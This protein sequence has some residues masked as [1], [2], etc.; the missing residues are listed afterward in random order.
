[1]IP[2]RG[3]GNILCYRIRKSYQLNSF[4]YSAKKILLQVDGGQ[5]QMQI[6]IHIQNH[7]VANGYVQCVGSNH[8][9]SRSDN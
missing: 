3:N 1:M 2:G 5:L 4:I 7:S 9:R 6:D 8:S